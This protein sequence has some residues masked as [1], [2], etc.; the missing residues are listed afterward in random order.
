MKAPLLLVD[1]E[2]GLCK[3][4]AISLSDLGYPVRTAADGVEALRLF[5]EWA[6][7]IVITDIKMPGLDGVELL[8]RIKKERPETEVIM[9][10]GHGDMDLAVLSLKHEAT[11]FITKPINDEALAVALR[12]AEERIALRRRL[13]DYTEN[14]ERLVAQKTRELLAAER[15]AA[16]GQTIAGLA[17]A[18]KNLASGLE[19]GIFV[20]GKGLEL[21][22]RN[23]SRQ[24]WEILRDNVE[25]LKNLSLNLL[26][27]AKPGPVRRAPGDPNQPVRAVLELMRPRAEKAG[28]RLAAD[29][30]PDPPPLDYDPDGLHICL[31][32]LMTN[33]L[34]ACQ[35]KS[36]G[37]P[38][39][40]VTVRTRLLD[41]G[42]FEYQV[43][44]NG[45]G[46]A[47]AA[48]ENLFCLFFTTKGSAGTGLGLMITRKIVE[49]L[50]GEIVVESEPGRGARFIIRL[51]ADRA[52]PV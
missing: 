29:L 24:G 2:A 19:A 51:P 43:E 47:P 12:R 37:Q 41:S 28:A 6:P 8:D 34:E 40:L 46:L 52:R 45:P 30:V 31:L 35:E 9:M 3:V 49:E 17:H 18:I 42:G 15:L 7:P 27:Y 10:T 5:Q 48:R 38:D 21:D 36:A 22:H 44:D 23:Y 16:V 20:L 39:G 32:N 26:S 13:K 14:L 11:D 25:K 4:L 33:A 50:Q 1:D